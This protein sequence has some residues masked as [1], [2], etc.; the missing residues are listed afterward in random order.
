MLKPLNSRFGGSKNLEFKVFSIGVI[1]QVSWMLNISIGATIF[2]PPRP[3]WYHLSDW[4][5]AKSFDFGR[6]ATC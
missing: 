4:L 5:D 1:C 2:E 6:G 3:C